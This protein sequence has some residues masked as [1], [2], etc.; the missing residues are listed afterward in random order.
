MRETL[1][2]IYNS[3]D[4]ILAFALGIWFISTK[5]KL[6]NAANPSHKFPVKWVYFAGYVAILYGII[7]TIKIFS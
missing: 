7:N 6:T 3:V 4:V 2:L 1:T 5:G